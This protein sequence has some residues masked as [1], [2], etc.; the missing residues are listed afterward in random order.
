MAMI[1]ETIEETVCQSRFK[2]IQVTE[3]NPVCKVVQQSMC[4]DNGENCMEFPQRV[5]F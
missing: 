5:I 3:D 4:D 1:C 2:F